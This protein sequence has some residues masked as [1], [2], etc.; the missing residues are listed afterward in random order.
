[1]ESNLSATNDYD[2]AIRQI[3]AADPLLEL[4]PARKQGIELAN[5]ESR[6]YK[7]KHALNPRCVASVILHPTAFELAR[8][9]EWLTRGALESARRELRVLASSQSHH[10]LIE[11]R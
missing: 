11:V 10:E 2:R 9:A 6:G 4:D 3:L 8:G 7:V 1:M 5:G